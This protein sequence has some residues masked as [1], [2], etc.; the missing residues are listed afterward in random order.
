MEVC[1]NQAWGTVCDDAWDITDAA[2]ACRQ[3][4][5]SGTSKYICILAYFFVVAV[6]VYFVLLLVL[7]FRYYK[8]LHLLI[9]FTFQMPQ[10]SPMLYLVRE[11]V[12]LYWTMWLALD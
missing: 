2:V 11:M 1:Q 5:F 9:Y 10:P 3:L 7:H 4:G 8:P 6:V 12:P